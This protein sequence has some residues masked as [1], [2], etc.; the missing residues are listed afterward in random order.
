M[1]DFRPGETP[2]WQICLFEDAAEQ[3][4]LDCAGAVLVVE[5]TD[6]PFTP[7]ISW[8]DRAGGVAALTMTRAQTSTV[9]RQ[10]RYKV[11]LRLE[12]PGPEIIVLDDVPLMVPRAPEGAPI[13]PLEGEPF[14]ANS[15][16]IAGRVDGGR[17]LSIRFARLG[18][19]G[20]TGGVGP[21]GP[22]GEAATNEDPGD[23]ALIFDNQ[24][25]F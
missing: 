11:R 21:Q 6:L 15:A 23:L 5:A 2:S 13:R 25:L 9:Q 22:Q 4:P 19:R 1:L 16:P 3:R 8:S 18:I 7:T 12:L 24:L 14:R 20:F 17:R 10:R